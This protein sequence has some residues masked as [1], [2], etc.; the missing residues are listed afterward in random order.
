MDTTNATERFINA[1]NSDFT[2]TTSQPEASITSNKLVTL[3][4]LKIIIQIV[5]GVV[6]IIIVTTNS[7]IIHVYR[8][9]PKLQNATFLCL[10]SLAIADLLTGIIIPISQVAVQL[11]YY[12]IGR[13][14][15]ILQ[16]SLW[17]VQFTPM[18]ISRLHLLL[19]AFERYAA[20]AHPIHHRRFMS[21]GLCLIIIVSGWILSL[22]LGLIIIPY[23]DDSGNHFLPLPYILSEILAFNLLTDI[24]IM[25]CYYRVYKSINKPT[26]KLQGAIAN[27]RVIRM[28]QQ[29][30]R[31]VKMIGMTIG[32]FEACWMPFML[33]Y[34]PYTITRKF[35][36]PRV[37]IIN[38]F[39]SVGQL[40][41]LCNSFINVFIYAGIS[42]IFR[43]G[44]YGVLDK[45]KRRVCCKC[46]QIAP[47]I[48]P[49]GDTIQDT[50]NTTNIATL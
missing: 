46:N 44:L 15:P 40:L 20:T 45:V 32:V 50:Y 41:A 8:T 10:A 39:L 16:A 6:G 3:T 42:P 30:K 49:S 48:Q 31:M 37:V 17:V 29:N 19:I 26:P 13:K 28:N 23:H 43:A 11:M 18:T 33:I 38:N 9:T 4:M 7:L 25:F 14:V 22:L 34:I 27:T 21:K 36:Y 12:Y 35:G 47:I 1:E 24:L 5:I 2:N